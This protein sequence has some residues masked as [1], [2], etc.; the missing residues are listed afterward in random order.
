MTALATGSNCIEVEVVPVTLSSWSCIN[1]EVVVKGA[2][3]SYSGLKGNYP[4]QIVVVVVLVKFTTGGVATVTLHNLMILH[5]AVRVR[6]C[7]LIL[8][9]SGRLSYC[10]G[11]IVLSRI[12]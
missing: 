2:C 8:F 11:E 3:S 7:L 9:E 10:I 1:V 5:K 4:A 12:N 6:S